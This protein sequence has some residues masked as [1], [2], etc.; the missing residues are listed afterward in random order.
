LDEKR[1]REIMESHGVIDVF[2]EGIPVWIEALNGSEAKVRYLNR[3]QH[4]LVSAGEL[5]EG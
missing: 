5:Q 1:V 3:E 4:F 2:Y